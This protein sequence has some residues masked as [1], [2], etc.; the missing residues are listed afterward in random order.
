[1]GDYVLT[2]TVRDENGLWSTPDSMLVTTFN[3]SPTAIAGPDLSALVG[4]P[5]SLDGSGSSDPDGDP[6]TFAWALMAPSGSLAVLN[7]NDTSR[8]TFIP[9]LPGNYTATLTVI[10]GF[11][12][13]GFDSL[14]VSAITVDIFA[15]NQVAAA[16]NAVGGLP[17]KSVTNRGNRQA[18]QRLLTQ[19]IHALQTGQDKRAWIKLDQAIDR[20]DGCVLHGVPDIRG[21][22]RDWVTNCAAQITIYNELKAALDTL[23]P[24]LPGEV[25]GDF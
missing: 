8:P 4:H 14:V 24:P 2:L 22:G 23:S 7:G 17:P 21:S 12:G 10:D 9:D 18:L 13:A 6:M 16:L 25:V 5:V 15:I 1:M 19:A 11:G 20:T 3:A